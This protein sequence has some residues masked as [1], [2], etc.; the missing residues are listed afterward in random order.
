MNIQRLAALLL[1]AL[2]CLSFADDCQLTLSN[3]WLI[4][5]R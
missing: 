4:T 3:K 5:I 1:F 2:P